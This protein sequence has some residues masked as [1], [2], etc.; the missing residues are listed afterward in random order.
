MPTDTGEPYQESIG[1]FLGRGNQRP[2]PA[3]LR[4][5]L[6]GNG[7]GKVGEGMSLIRHKKDLNL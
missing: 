4:A 6:T 5:S 1:R 3:T 2:A 7:D